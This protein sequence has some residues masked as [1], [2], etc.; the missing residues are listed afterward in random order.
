MG[1]SEDPNTSE[2]S[3]SQPFLSKPSSSSSEVKEETESNQ[4]YLQITY[5]SGPRSVKDL[6]FLI[7]FLLFHISTFALGIFAIAHR[8]TNAHASST[9]DPV[10]SSCVET[11]S[12][13]SL[14]SSP[15]WV[16]PLTW[17]LLLT[18]LLSLPFSW[19]LLLSLKHYTK[20]IVYASLPFFI[21]IPLFLNVYWFVACNLRSSCSHVFPLAFQILLLVFVFLLIGIVVWILIVNRHRLQLT[22]NIIKVAS[23][24]LSHNLAL[25]AVLPSMTL[26]LLVYYVPLVVFLV[27]SKLN[28]K[29]VVKELEGDYACV[30]KED[31]WVP[32]YFVLVILTMLWSAAAT[33]EAQVY[34]ISG[35][36]ANWYFSKDYQAPKRGIR[37]SLRNAFGP[38]SGTI[39]LSGSLILVVRMVRCVVD[40][41]R[42]ED[43]PGIVNLVLRCCV[44]ALLTTVDFLNKFTINFAAI[45]GEAYCSS[46][47]MTY[48]L[49]RRNLLSAVFVETISSRLLAGIVFVLSAIYTI[50]VCAVLK[51]GINLGADSYF[52]AA[53]AWVLLLVVLGYLVHVLDNV[54]D[55]IYVCYAIDRDRGEV[56]K[57]DVHEVYVHLPRSRSL[58]QSVPTR[59]LGV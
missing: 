30:W 14:Y 12:T 47:K 48:E 55:T 34:V 3:A 54:I 22:V 19:A 5:N 59:T 31:L 46:A 39:C 45:T 49:L 2:F 44:N 10:T 27:F 25:F 9:Y 24:A 33:V 23:D 18:L 40:S 51:A 8:N 43:A 50:V 32:F 38:S 42:Q 58:S 35:T 4:Q 16:K 29:L 41:A 28:G 21:F 37:T 36:I 20:H 13:L 17:T 26:A 6:L 15:H 53:M 7:L 57:Q 52:V 56:C 11:H 1:S